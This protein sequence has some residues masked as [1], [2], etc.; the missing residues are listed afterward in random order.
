[1]PRFAW[2]SCKGLQVPYAVYSKNP[3]DDCQ[4]HAGPEKRGIN[5]STVHSPSLRLCR[6]VLHEASQVRLGRGRCNEIL[7]VKYGNFD[8]KENT[9]KLEGKLHILAWLC[10]LE[11]SN[12]SFLCGAWAVDQLSTGAGTGHDLE[13]YSYSEA[14]AK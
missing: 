8:Q 5:A 13:D 7:V 12:H 3:G 14:N 9:K 2:L 10:S 11:T 4:V 1:M 6:P